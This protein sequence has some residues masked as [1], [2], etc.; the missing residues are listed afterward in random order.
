MLK[1]V[2]N[3]S[4]ISLLLEEKF[5]VSITD[6]NGI[7]THV[8]QSFCGLSKYSEAEL[9]GE[10]Y[11]ML[12]PDYTAKTFIEEV[13]MTVTEG[14]VWQR[15]LQ[16]FAKDGSPYW[17]HATIVPIYDENGE[18]I[19][20]ISLDIDVTAKVLTNRP[21]K[22]TVENLL[23][24]EHALDQSSVVVITNRQGVITY[25]NDKFC[26]LS[27]YSS[28]ELVGQTHQIVNSGF[29]PK[30][31]FKDMWQTIGDGA[32]WQGEVQNRA[33]DGT[34]YWV[35]T[36]IVPFLDSK[37]R[38]YQYISIRT[39]ITDCKETERALK[40][41]LKNDFRQTVRNLQNAVFKYTDNGCGGITITLIEGKT[42]KKLGFSEENITPEEMHKL[43]S[44]EEITTYLGHLTHALQGNIVQF[45]LPYASRTFLIYLSPNF[46]NQKVIEVV[47]TVIDIS[48]RIQAEKLV[49]HMAYYDYLTGLPN[50]RLFRKHT[51]EIIKQAAH[52]DDTI[53]IMFIDL[54][55]FKHVNDSMGHS[56]GDQLLITIGE[57]LQ[58]CVRKGDMVARLGGDEFVILFTSTEISE[59]NKVA[60]RIVEKVSQP[61]YFENH[62]IFVTP[63][64]GIC[65][66]PDDGDDFDTLMNN[67][68]TAMYVVKEKGRNNFQFFTEELHHNAKE[69]HVLEQE[70][71]QALQEQQFELYYQPKFNLQTNEITGVE[72]LIR[73]NH[74]SKGTLFPA[75]FL[76]L[77]EETGLIIPIGQWVLE[78]ACL[79]AKQWQDQGLPAIS[80]SVNISSRQFK[81]PSF[82]KL[83]KDTLANIDLPAHQ[84]NLEI[85]ENL[86]EGVSYSQSILQPLR[87]MGIQ[88][89]L[90][91]FGTG[92]S[93]LHAL[94]NLP[95]T[96]VK[97]GR[98]FIQELSANNQAVVKTIIDLANNFEL[99]VIAE[100]VETAE[101]AAILQGLGCNEMQGFLYSKPLPK[102]QIEALLH[103]IFY[104]TM[105]ELP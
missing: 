41:A 60:T 105:K 14:K 22:R 13:T 47:G 37:G 32:I 12:N 70:L 94:K 95:I 72:A 17:V 96:Q 34:Y 87:E 36:T 83:V 98:A 66:F 90:D 10:S 25:V 91:D 54:D 49:E 23:N 5:C 59:V 40:L 55:H 102:E 29:H 71:Q 97:I 68:D 43:F 65:M 61:F 28:D 93:S 75:T 44:K 63:S 80:M 30:S 101:Q 50:R 76:S 31:F 27:Q 51:K 21:Y 56:I 4:A 99:D 15:Q 35:N 26:K 53:S 84:L 69:K 46:D 45:E 42:A 92:Y 3:I 11:S 62:H 81:H 58:S 39:D 103:T 79:Q 8:N 104:S 82:S 16:A 18:I 85:T 78:T 48:D 100:G 86:L 73:W 67:A 64:I 9:I 77:I 38:P 89:S 1:E 24:I 6:R 20:F 74:P 52:N 7:I 2:N 33:K 57:R 88:I 19:Q